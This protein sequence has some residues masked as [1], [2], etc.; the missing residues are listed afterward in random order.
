MTDIGLDALTDDQLVELARALAGELAKRQPAVV[1]AAKAAV[2]A[3]TA[4]DTASQDAQWA[5]KKWLGKMVADHLGA[6][7]KL[8]VWRKG[9]ETRVYVTNWCGR[10]YEVIKGVYYVTGDRRNPPRSC[11]LTS[12]LGSVPAPDREMVRLIAAHAAAAYPAGV[13][14]ACDQVAALDYATSPEPD[15]VAARAQALRAA[16]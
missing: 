14:I 7:Y 12:A 16:Q 11:T 8:S 13:E 2:A 6:G 1:D 10:A 9:A 15:D 4:A 3:A 5:R